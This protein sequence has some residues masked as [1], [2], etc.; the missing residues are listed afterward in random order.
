[1]PVIGRP[2]QARHAAH[3]GIQPDAR[4]RPAP[5]GR[6]RPLVIAGVPRSGSTWTKQVLEQDG[7]LLSLME[8]DSEG[9]QPT[10]IR[11]KRDIGRFP[12]LHPGDRDEPYRRL[13]SWIL[14]GAP[15]SHRQRAAQ[16][17]LRRTRPSQRALHLSGRGSPLMTLAGGLADLRLDR[18]NPALY[19]HALLVKSVHAPL[20]IEWV[21]AE[22]DVDVLVL[23]RHP[24]S[25]VASWLE[26]RSNERVVP[27]AGDP[28]V[29]RLADTWGVRP[30]RPDPLTVTIWTVGVLLTALESSARRNPAWTVRT[31]EQLCRDPEGEFRELYDVL[32]LR[33]SPQVL[34]FIRG[35]DRPGTGYATK[36]V[37]ATLPGDW[38]RRLDAAQQ[39]ELHRVLSEF[40]FAGR[41]GLD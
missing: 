15:T 5:P 23:L 14:E 25:V 33:W 3:S 41:W 40:P 39:V 28:G 36:R 24:G 34:E 37:A 11:A 7:D 8:P 26:V 6:K 16:E 12:L 18:R 10:A 17:V 35:R 20:S 19:D 27:L 22:F 21:A 30:P 13:W 2:D 32:G 29:R 38:R 31:H 1:M 4:V 9:Y